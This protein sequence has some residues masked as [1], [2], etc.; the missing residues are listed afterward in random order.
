MVGLKLFF[1]KL[2]VTVLAAL[3]ICTKT[4]KCSRGLWRMQIV[5]R[6]F[7]VAHVQLDPVRRHGGTNQLQVLRLAI[8]L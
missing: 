6:H 1:C 3:C 5:D 7:Q 2:N 8:S 4:H